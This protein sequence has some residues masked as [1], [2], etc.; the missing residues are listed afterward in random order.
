MTAS[1]I[2]VEVKN[3]QG[4]L[5]YGSGAL[6]Q[7]ILTINSSEISAICQAVTVAGDVLR[8]T[9]NGSTAKWFYIEDRKDSN[10]GPSDDN[11][12]EAFC[13]IVNTGEKKASGDNYKI[14]NIERYKTS[15]ESG[16][17]RGVIIHRRRA[18]TGPCSSSGHI[19]YEQFVN[20][21]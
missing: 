21:I 5:Y 3:F 14:T 18:S 17:K 4:S 7:D 1:N 20:A 2:D 8:H 6:F 16:N 13:L 19:T 12:G 9:Q 10:C 11:D 15:M